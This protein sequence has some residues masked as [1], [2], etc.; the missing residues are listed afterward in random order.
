MEFKKEKRDDSK[1]IGG[2]GS[3]ALRP[4]RD[5]VMSLKQD[6]VISLKLDPESKKKGSSRLGSWLSHLRSRKIIPQTIGVRLRKTGDYEIGHHRRL[7]PDPKRPGR[8]IHEK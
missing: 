1:L 3:S 8:V 2:G 4:L 6:E 5:A 7:V